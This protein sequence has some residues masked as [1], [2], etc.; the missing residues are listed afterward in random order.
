[1][2]N[3]ILIGMAILA[4]AAIVWIASIVA[5][6]KSKNPLIRNSAIIFNLIVVSLF[7]MYMVKAWQTKRYDDSSYQTAKEELVID[8]IRIPAGSKLTVAPQNGISKKPDF[9]TFSEVT[10]SR[11]VEWKGMEVNGMNRSAYQTEDGYQA[12][13]TMNAIGEAGT[14]DVEGWSCRS[15][16]EM[17][18]QALTKGGKMPSSPDDYFLFGAHFISLLPVFFDLP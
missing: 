3:L 13:L 11:P 14:V 1:M 6:V 5:I 9:S 7:G 10:F 4:M 18:W 17:E 8:G 16:G 12:T 15:D 2:E